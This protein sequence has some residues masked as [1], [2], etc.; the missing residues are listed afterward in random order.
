MKAS[1]LISALQSLINFHGDLEVNGFL[2]VSGNFN[3][4]DFSQD[5]ELELKSIKHW[6]HK[7]N[8]GF[9]ID[10]RESK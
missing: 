4:M 10:T 8:Q 6:D 1:D 3:G 7:G 2:P 5:I 9:E